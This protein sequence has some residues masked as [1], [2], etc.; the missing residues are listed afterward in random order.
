M[1]HGVH[2]ILRD[3]QETQHLPRDQFIR[4]ETPGWRVFDFEGQPRREEEIERQ[5]ERILKAPQLVRN[6]EYHSSEDLIVESPSSV[7]VSLPVVLS[8]VS[9][10]VEAL[11]LSGSFEL[12][13]QLWSQFTPVAGP[14]NVDV[15]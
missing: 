2:E 5:R 7:D 9:V 13:H 4:L 10:L 1:T 14:V 12:V 6:R 8:K 15:A 3:Y 11:R